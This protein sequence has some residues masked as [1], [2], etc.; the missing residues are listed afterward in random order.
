MELENKVLS[1]ELLSMLYESGKS[2][3][4]AE[5]C[6]SGRVASVISSV[7]GASNYFKGGIVCYSD[8]VKVNVLGVSADTIAEK[9][10]V[11]EEVA[12]QMVEGALKVLDVDYAISFTGYAG[13]SGGDG[14][15]VGTIWIACGN[16]EEIVT[17]KLTEDNGRDKNLE[18][19][20]HTGMN[21]LVKFV[22]EHEPE[23]TD[24]AEIITNF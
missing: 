12:K 1:K 14:V 3:G 21:M 2:L 13:P 18:N 20:I 9:S 16:S 23:V 22:R 24:D 5:S 6:T 7:P 17:E 10:A 15:P 19:A 4:T 11:S 8:E